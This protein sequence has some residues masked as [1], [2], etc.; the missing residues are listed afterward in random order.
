[1]RWSGGRR[2]RLI[3]KTSDRATVNSSGSYGCRGRPF[4]FPG[5][6][7][8]PCD[9]K[10]PAAPDYP[11][12]LRCIGSGTAPAPYAPPYPRYPETHPAQ[13]PKGRLYP[14]THLRQVHL[15]PPPSDGSPAEIRSY[16]LFHATPWFYDRD[17][18]TGLPGAHFRIGTIHP[19][20][21]FRATR[22]G[23][24]EGAGPWSVRLGSAALRVTVTLEDDDGEDRVL[25]VDGEVF[26]LES[27]PTAVVTGLLPGLHTVL[28]GA[29]GHLGRAM[30]VVLKEAETREIR[31]RLPRR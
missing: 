30:R 19:G 23:R 11:R 8:R 22:Y 12:L 24:L 10:I 14:A 7:R 28:V 3:A 18:L 25:C 1:M 4:P 5:P 6:A 27:D 29:A 26:Q 17:D 9:L 2:S 21:G 15:A 31:V 16:R 13:G 20:G